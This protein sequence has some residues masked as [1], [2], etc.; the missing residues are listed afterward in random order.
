MVGLDIKTTDD[1]IKNKSK[2]EWKKYVKLK[3]KEEALKHLKNENNSK[4]SRN[5]EHIDL[6]MQCYLKQNKNK[7]LSQIIFAVR[8]GTFDLKTWKQWKYSDNLCVGCEK[9][10][11]NMTH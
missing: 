1:E 4:R 9:Q 5:I 2:Y 10:E 7:D 11:E 6:E 3:V 8:A